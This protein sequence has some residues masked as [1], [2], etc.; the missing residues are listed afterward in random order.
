MASLV[1]EEFALHVDIY[2]LGRG[3]LVTS[4]MSFL[5]NPGI[6]GQTGLVIY[7]EKS[8]MNTAVFVNASI[9]FS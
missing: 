5:Q 2:N 9:G 8:T 4:Y 3:F 7:I 1:C 6:Q